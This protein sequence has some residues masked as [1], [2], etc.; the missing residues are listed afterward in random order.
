VIADHDRG[1]H[2]HAKAGLDG[3]GVGVGVVGDL[4]EIVP[5]LAKAV[6]AARG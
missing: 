2:H 6:R 5:A 3:T 1:R 4:F